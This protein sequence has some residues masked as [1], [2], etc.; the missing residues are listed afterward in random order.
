MW[1][2]AS[3]LINGDGCS[4]EKGKNGW[5]KLMNHLYVLSRLR[6]SGAAH[7]LP[8]VHVSIASSRA[9]DLFTE[10][11]R[12]NT[13]TGFYDFLQLFKANSGEKREVYFRVEPRQLFA[14]SIPDHCP[15]NAFKFSA[16]RSE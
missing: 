1:G 3:L 10:F 5:V 2:P 16:V 12:Q 11:L 6:L 9:I 14:P 4:F 7:I 15:L 8:C 13:L